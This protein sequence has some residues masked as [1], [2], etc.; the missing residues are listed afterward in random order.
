MNK[1]LLLAVL[2][3]VGA[4]AVIYQQQ[5][6]IVSLRS[7]LQDEQARSQ[8]EAA[9][10][11]QAKADADQ[12]KSSNEVFKQESAELRKQI[13]DQ[14]TTSLVQDPKVG[15]PKEPKGENF[16]KG[17][18]KMFTDPAMKKSMRSQQLIG[19]RM[20]YSDLAKQLG[21]SPQENEQLL[22]ILADR[23]TDM[24][25]A[26]MAA[27]Q[28]GD[29]DAETAKLTETTKQYEEQLKAVLGEDRYKQMQTYEQSMGDRF[30]MQQW[31]GQFAASG[32]PLEPA[33]KDQLLGLMREERKKSPNT[34]NFGA[35]QNS[36]Q[37]MQAMQTDE[38]VNQII[39]SQQ[40]LN[41]RVLA[42]SRDFLNADQ[43]ATLE[44][45]QTQQTEML[46]AQIK[47][48]GA[49]LGGGTK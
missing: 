45:A 17:L 34:A 12:L 20:L 28:G 30:M 21:L 43:V 27:L 26:G 35:P 40:E 39:A 2:V 32:S 6:T 9:D 18:A 10:F 7:R 16:M 29:K 23:Q 1:P 44:K 5:Q 36:A 14:P 41:Q 49:L 37:A 47:M 19:I 25:A 8:M 38:G 4:G 46:G 22:E 15:G 42:R 31:E 11:A 13:A 3:C 24:S 33:Q 48:S